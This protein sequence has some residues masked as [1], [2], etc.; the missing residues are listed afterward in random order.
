LLKVDFEMLPLSMKARH[1]QGN[2][3][4]VHGNHFEASLG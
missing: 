4:D 1:I 3:G 2:F